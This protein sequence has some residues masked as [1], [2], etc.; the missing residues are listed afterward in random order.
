MPTNRVRN[1]EGI[2]TIAA[3]NDETTGVITRAGSYDV[4]F[5]R[6]DF[7]SDIAWSHAV[8]RGRPCQYYIT[9]LEHPKPKAKGV[10]LIEE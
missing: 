6:K 4:Q 2:G 5:N 10:H 8:L 9:N 1:S 3:I 7:H